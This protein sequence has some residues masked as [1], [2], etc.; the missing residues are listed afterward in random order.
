MIDRSETLPAVAGAATKWDRLAQAVLSGH[1]LSAD[2]ATAVLEAPDDELPALLAAAFR[3]RYHYFGRRVRLNFLLNAKSGLCGEDCGYCSQ[4]KTSRA[5][6]PKYNLVDEQ[7]VLDAARTATERGATTFCYVISARGP[8]EREIAAVESFV[9]KVKKAHDLKVCVSL[10]MLTPQQARRLADCGV[11]RVNHNVNT[12]R[13]FHAEICSTH[14]YEDRLKTLL[15]VR[16]AGMEICSGGIV[17]MGENKKDVVRMALEL[18]DLSVEAIPVN[19][20]IPIDT[21]PLAGAG[22]LNPPYCL[23]VLAMV[24]MVNPDR[25]IRLAAGREL[26]LGTLQPLALFAANSIFVGDYLTTKGQP[27]EEDY[28]MIRDLGFQIEKDE[29]PARPAGQTAIDR[30]ID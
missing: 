9:P 24:R 13:R 19:F 11:D 1:E 14:T 10:G 17:G 6:I 12:S 25:E 23:K 5:D 15:A 26:H 30:A 28:R 21:T 3:L 16:E 18:R 4:S 2:E 7:T 29:H 8:S 20:L 22:G 27:P